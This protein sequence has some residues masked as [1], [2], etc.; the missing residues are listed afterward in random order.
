MD[1]LKRGKTKVWGVQIYK[2]DSSICLAAIHS[3]GI[4]VLKN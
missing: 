3:G 4:K 2:D 1:C